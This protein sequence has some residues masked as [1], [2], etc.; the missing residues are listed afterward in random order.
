MG[1]RGDSPDW[2]KFLQTCFEQNKPWNEM[3][4]AMLDP[5][6]EDES[7]RGAGF[8]Y[9]KRLE[10][11]GQNPIDYP[12]L[13]RDV[14]R[15]LLGVDLQCAQCH[16][17]LFIDD[18]KQQEFQGLF[19]IYKNLTIRTDVKY[20]A[21]AEKATEQKLEFISVF[22]PTKQETGPRIPFV[23]EVA[24][25]EQ[26]PDPKS[27]APL[28]SAL[29]PLAKELPKADNLYFTRNIANR[30]WFVMMG[31]GL[32]EP[33]DL[34]HTGNPSTHPELLD[35]LAQEFAAHNF[36]IKWLLREIALSE[37]YQR[38]STAADGQELPTRESYLVGNEKRLSA[39][40]LLWSTLVA[41]GNVERLTKED[42]A[43][44]KEL[45]DLKTRFVK[46]FANEPREPEVDFNATVAGALFLMN[47]EKLL[48]LLKPQA[49]NLT[50]RLLAM[51]DQQAMTDE[52]FLSILTRMPADEERAAVTE[53]LGAHTESREK[54]L[55]HIV[56]S[57]LSSMEF[58]V[59]H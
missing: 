27:K 19:A 2:Q 31:R 6:H 8:F 33:L 20:P 48:D 44:K 56:W 23:K 26:P 18:Y 45:E 30:L 37:A 10:H 50:E 58:G 21:V 14:G 40:Q 49:G 13:T 7:L 12:G 4:A 36:D 25:V 35:T 39:E 1:R 29:P 42:E 51:S 5:P 24:W 16:N 53:Y 22:D 15:L 55:A 57:M 34:F 3:A 47:D 46:A 43:A 52:L 9:T 28:L 38:S 11:Y 59:N 41:T 54:A 32:V 17:H